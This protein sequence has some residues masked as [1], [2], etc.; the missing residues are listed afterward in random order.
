[1]T[2]LT[3]SNFFLKHCFRPGQRIAS[4]NPGL[5]FLIK[6]IET[7]IRRILSPDVFLTGIIFVVLNVI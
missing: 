3:L 7:K 2:S 5:F 6:L 4:L 1:M